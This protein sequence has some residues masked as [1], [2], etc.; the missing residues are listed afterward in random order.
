MKKM[1]RLAARGPA[2]VGGWA[3]LVL[4]VMAAC[5][6]GADDL[7]KDGYYTAEAA[8]F[9]SKGWKEYITIYI[10]GGRIVSA[11]YNSRNASGFVRSWDMADKRRS[12]MTRG[13]NHGKYSR[14]YTA[15]LLNRQ[16]PDKLTPIPGAVQAL[17]GFRIL[18]EAALGQARDGN[19]RVTFVRLWTEAE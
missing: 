4:V 11:E 19:R 1:F 9:D 13:T 8:G 18:V 3:G 16:D 14:I 5:A 15:A 17:A 10:L 6:P 7:L 2:A 12:T